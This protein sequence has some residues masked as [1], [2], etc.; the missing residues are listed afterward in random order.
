MVMN[1]DGLFGKTS[2]LI[3]ENFLKEQRAELKQATDPDRKMAILQKMHQYYLVVSKDEKRANTYLGKATALHG[4][5]GSTTQ[6]V[7]LY[8]MNRSKYLALTKSLGISYLSELRLIDMRLLAKL[9][10][11]Y[12]QASALAKSPDIKAIPVQCELL[13]DYIVSELSNI[14]FCLATDPLRDQA[15]SRD[16]SSARSRILGKYLLQLL[17]LQKICKDWS[18]ELDRKI[19]RLISL[20]KALSPLI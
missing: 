13:L 5:Y 20:A 6:T 10:K 19:E 12:K 9:S 7:I 11:C 16:S 3:T 8:Q 14:L 17:G 4:K 2:F 15:L 18:P 1:Y